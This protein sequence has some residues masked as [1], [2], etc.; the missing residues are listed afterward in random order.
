VSQRVLEPDGYR[1]GKGRH[2]ANKIYS[3]NIRFAQI[4]GVS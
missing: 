4:Y 2:A 1:D 3:L